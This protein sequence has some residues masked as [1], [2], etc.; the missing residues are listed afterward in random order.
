M[1]VLFPPIGSVDFVLSFSARAELLKVFQF[2]VHLIHQFLRPTWHVMSLIL[3]TASIELGKFWE[4][5]NKVCVL[6]VA[7]KAGS[8]ASVKAEASDIRFSICKYEGTKDENAIS[9][10]QHAKEKWRWSACSA[11]GQGSFWQVRRRPVLKLCIHTS[12][13][14]NILGL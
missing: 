12:L 11:M 7:T 5:F 4:K 10:E 2:F 14:H 3:Q 6:F 8:Q 9:A 13:Q 1:K